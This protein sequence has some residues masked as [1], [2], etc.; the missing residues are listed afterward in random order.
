MIR[1]GPK[2]AHGSDSGSFC[3]KCVKGGKLVT[4]GD[5]RWGDERG[6]LDGPPLPPHAVGIG[7]LIGNVPLHVPEA[8][9]P[10]GFKQQ[11]NHNVVRIA[12]GAGRELARGGEGFE[13][14]SC[15][16]V[17]FERCGCIAESYEEM[18]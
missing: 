3:E 17:G 14:D 4:F 15:G 7:R 5:C 16:R 18:R 8:C 13:V 11:M 10:R 12:D 1:V 9:V 6:A 2:E